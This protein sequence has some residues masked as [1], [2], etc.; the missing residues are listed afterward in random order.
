[1]SDGQETRETTSN[2]HGDVLPRDAGSASQD[3][4]RASASDNGGV[5]APESSGSV[6]Q[7]PEGGDK[8]RE[9]S[10][11]PA[12]G[13][14]DIKKDTEAVIAE[15]RKFGEM[16][17]DK[18]GAGTVVISETIFR[19][20]FHATVGLPIQTCLGLLNLTKTHIENQLG[21][22]DIRVSK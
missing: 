10:G 20:A 5:H 18:Y 21:V 14:D 2:D 16:M 6:R 19:E 17:M 22:K 11:N 1:M 12:L 4:R 15:V 13:P 9:A 3:D 7:D 8:K